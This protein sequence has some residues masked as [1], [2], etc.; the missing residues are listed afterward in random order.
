MIESLKEFI[1]SNESWRYMPSSALKNFIESDSKGLPIDIQHTK[2]PAILNSNNVPLIDNHITGY[3]T[4]AMD[5]QIYSIHDA[6][7]KIPL[8]DKIFQKDDRV[9]DNPF[10]KSSYT[11]YSTGYVLYIPSGISLDKPIYLNNHFSL[12]QDTLISRIAIVCDEGSEVEII[13]HNTGGSELGY[14]NIFSSI[15]CSKGSSLNYTQLSECKSSIIINADVTASSCSKISYNTLSINSGL[16]RNNMSV[17]LAGDMASAE[18]S[19]L[20]FAKENDHIEF[21][22]E[23][24]HRSRKTKSTQNFRGIL[25][26]SSSGFFNG[27]VRISRNGDGSEANQSNKNIIFGDKARMNSNPQLV[28]ETDDV[29]CTHGSTTGQIDSD[30]LFYLRSR[31]IPVELAYQMVVAG[32]SS[33]I[34]QKISNDELRSYISDVIQESVSKVAS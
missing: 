3:D 12:N 33:E 28:I 31:G 13:E 23:M 4:S 17:N 19:G 21:H 18:L 11:D 20:F 16:Y 27:L 32:F 29:Q 15:F 2:T 14:M 24:K 25:A 34:F 8:I 7:G 22:T 6:M 26:G 5:F 9:D 1:N 10:I 30:T